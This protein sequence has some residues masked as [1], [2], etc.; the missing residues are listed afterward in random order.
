MLLLILYIKKSTKQLW[1]IIKPFILKIGN[2]HETLCLWIKCYKDINMFQVYL[3]LAG[4]SICEIGNFSI[5]LLLRNL[6]PEGSKVWIK[7]FKG[8]FRHFWIS[9]I[10]ICLPRNPHLL[11]FYV[12]L[13]FYINA[14]FFTI[15]LNLEL[16]S[17]FGETNIWEIV[18][19]SARDCLN[20]RWQ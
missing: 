3:G 15:V 10:K 9:K 7:I 17:E 12:F 1:L 20:D 19:F 14:S 4:F 13:L 11:L 18:V 5:H 2:V 16:T 6:R 8:Q